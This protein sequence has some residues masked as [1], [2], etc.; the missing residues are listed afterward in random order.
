MTVQLQFGTSVAFGF[1]AWAVVTTL[2]I[3]PQLSIQSRHRRAAAAAGSARI[4]LYRI[5][6]SGSRRGA[7]RSAARL[8]A[9][10]GLWRHRRRDFG[11]GRLGHAAEW[12]GGLSTSGA[13]SIYSTRSIRPTQPDYRQ[14]SSAPPISFPQRS[15]RCCSVASVQPT[16]R[17]R[18]ASRCCR[19]AVRSPNLG[20]FHCPLRLRPRLR[21]CPP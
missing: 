10:C 7:A 2:Y 20:R 21:G 4:P 12:R 16:D 18:S 15:F 14:G 3:W 19:G 13:V 8:R 6:L 1:V 9:R 11:F 17:I 5:G